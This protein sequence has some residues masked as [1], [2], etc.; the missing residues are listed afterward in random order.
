MTYNLTTH[1]LIPIWSLAMHSCDRMSHLCPTYE[2]HGDS[3]V[4]AE[5]GNDL[6]RR[7]DFWHIKFPFASRFQRRLQVKHIL[8]QGPGKKKKNY[9]EGKNSGFSNE[10][11]NGRRRRFRS[12]AVTKSK[13]KPSPW[14]ASSWT[15]SSS[16]AMIDRRLIFCTHLPMPRV[17]DWRRTTH[18]NLMFMSVI[19]C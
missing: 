16:S 7:L 9:R 12:W 19:S 15:E 5:W 4:A 2:L 11:H 10:L 3:C 18:R 17:F 1:E 13:L 14:K 6:T 8:H